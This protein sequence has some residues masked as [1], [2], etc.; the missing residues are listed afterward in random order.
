MDDA[1]N[2]R[3][4]PT[5]IPILSPALHC[6]AMTTLVY[7][8]T[9]F[10]Y[11]FLRPKSIFFA[12]SWAFVL[13][14]IMA[15]NEPAIWTEY[16]AL[17]VFGAGAVALYW[18]HFSI[19]FFHEWRKTAE[20]DQY[21]GT[22]HATLLLRLFGLPSPSAGLLHFWLEPAA[23]LAVSA[24]LRVAAGERHLSAW[25][26]FVALC[27]F[28]REAVNYWT[29][30]RKE[31]GVGETLRKVQEQSETL[32]G[33]RPVAE[34]PKATRT[35]PVKMKRNTAHAEEA[36]REAR[37]AKLLRLRA[38]YSLEK[39]EENYKTLIQ[40][41][42]PDANDNSPESNTAAAELN[43]AVAFFRDRLRH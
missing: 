23:V 26:A 3:P 36:A 21:P 42:H 33:D 5:P 8:R 22:S 40:L 24:A 13:A 11:V 14:F 29:S 28:A 34:P 4:V 6:V 16:R 20:P 19:T 43:E 9:S 32:S 27:M 38:P 41:D 31:K 17:A 7:L 10:G 25:L 39:A 2:Q 12:F 15:C 30:I 18:I 1:V 35:E 37:F